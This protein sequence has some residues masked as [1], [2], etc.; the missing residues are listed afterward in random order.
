MKTTFFLISL[1]CVIIGVITA[2]ITQGYFFGAAATVALLG[3]FIIQGTRRIP[4]NP[5]NKGLLTV[6]GKRTK[7][8]VDE[9]WHF[10]PLFPWLFG[11]VLVDV[12]KKERDIPA[13]SVRT[14]DLAEIKIPIALTWTPSYSDT[15]DENDNVIFTGGQDLI[16]YLN[17][18]G[19][20]GVNAQLED[21]V[22]ERLRE[23]AM[24]ADEGPQTWQEAIGA[25][26]EAV[27]ILLKAILGEILEPIPSTIPTPVLLKCLNSPPRKPTE[28]ECALWGQNWETA[29]GTIRALPAEDQDKLNRAVQRRRE[30]LARARQGNGHFNIHQL[31][32]TLNRL[33]IGETKP[34]GDLAKAAEA[35]VKEAQERRGEMYEIGTDLLKAQELAKK[36]TDSGK[37]ISIQDAFQI[38]M[39]WKATR[40][41][42]GFTVPGLSPA[43]KQILEIFLNKLS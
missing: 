34:L 21:I 15:L 13:E 25:K 38:I 17:S 41:G 20:E 32:V 42:K 37:E 35:E 27:A 1:I 11:V 10:F 43:L 33:N 26:E 36:I 22:H 14:P 30:E 31:G 23:W 6:L 24:S 29:M 8:V 40:E 2:N 3:T 7:M 18:G 5:P 12:K 9:G 19:E 39:E 16:E 28:K 4:N